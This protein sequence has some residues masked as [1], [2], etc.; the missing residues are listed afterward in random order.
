MEEFASR[1]AHY[2]AEINIL[3]PFREGNGRTQREFV[4]QLAANA[5]YQLDWS[6]A[7]KSIVLQASIRSA[8]DTKELSNVILSCMDKKP[9]T[10]RD[11]LLLKDLLKQV[12]GMPS[13][14]HNRYLPDHKDL[15][16]GVSKYRVRNVQGQSVLEFQLKGDTEL[17]SLRMEKVPHLNVEMK[18][19]WIEQAAQNV[20]SI[21][22]G[23]G[24]ER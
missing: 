23:K 22:F 19:K 15:N 6:K 16:R 24:L 11:N 10:T 14:L 13:A 17:R 3:H 7:D 12:E 2:M 21:S 8:V 18:N 20:K 1:A 4:R 5:G 9:E